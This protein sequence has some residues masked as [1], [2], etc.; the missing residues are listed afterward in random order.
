MLCLS[1]QDAF[2]ELLHSAG[3]K[4]AFIELE[5]VKGTSSFKSS[6]ISS[7]TSMYIQISHGLGFE[8]IHASSE[9]SGLFYASVLVSLIMNCS[10]TSC[11][12]QLREPGKYNTKI[13]SS[14]LNVVSLCQYFRVPR[15]NAN[16]LYTRQA[17]CSTCTWH[18]SQTD[19][20]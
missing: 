19:S 6:S 11:F 9:G 3:G 17:S 1:H 16:L 14:S 20:S 7:F 8:L 10:P 15:D 2:H 12:Q 13:R 5:N 4:R 18:G